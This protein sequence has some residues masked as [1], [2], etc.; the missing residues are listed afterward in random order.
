MASKLIRVRNLADQKAQFTYLSGAVSSGTSF[1]VRNI[2]AFS[3]NW[4]IQIG[5]TAE[6]TA[7][8]LILGTAVSGTALT[9]TGTSKYTHPTDTPVYAIKYDKLIFKRS[10]TGTAGTASPLTGGTIGI[11]PDSEFTVFEDTSGASG[12]AYKVSY[13]NSVTT[14]ESDESDW[15]STGGFSFYSLGAMRQ[16]VKNRLSDAGYIKSD[17]VIDDWI[18][19]WLDTM[20]NEAIDVNQDYGLG[21]VDVAFGT[22][23]FATVSSSDFKDFRK[24]E[25]TTNGSDWYVSNKLHSVDYM[26]DE[27]FSETHPYH[28][29][30]GDNVIGR[31]PKGDSGTARVTYYKTRDYLTTD[32]DELPVVMRAYSKSFVDYCTAQAY[33]MDEKNGA[34]DRYQAQAEKEKNQFVQQITPRQKTG[35]QY[36]KI[37][38]QVSV[39]DLDI[40]F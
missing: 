10:T 9:T 36:I 18:N 3:P 32:A 22:D 1:P 40:I 23:G 37:V 35:P 21:T 12:Y 27:D 4:A 30:F 34:G 20:N 25:F 17:D 38:E 15:I 16:R 31:L 29:Y 14:E 13:Y 2:S 8:I 19:E 39:D 28:W 5:K 6:E 24:I 11:T 26:P 33:Y 7:E